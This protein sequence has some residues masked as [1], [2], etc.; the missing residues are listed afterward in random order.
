MA[1]SAPKLGLVHIIGNL[2]FKTKLRLKS[3]RDIGRNFNH[4]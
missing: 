1:S 2:L 4:G 3:A